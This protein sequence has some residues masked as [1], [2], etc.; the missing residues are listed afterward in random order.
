MHRSHNLIIKV[1]VIILMLPFGVSYAAEVTVNDGFQAARKIESRY[2]NI[3]IESG[4]D[5]QTLVMRL[6]VPESIKSI[7][8]GSVPFSN[9]YTLGDQLDTLFLAVSEV[10]DMN[11]KRFKCNLKICRNRSGLSDIAGRLFGKNIQPGGFYVVAIDTLYIDAE[12]VTVNILG[13]ELS[14]AIQT[15]YFVVPPPA[16]IQEILAGYVEFQLRKYTNTLPR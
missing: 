5:I 9:S 7:I 12:N 6:S 13:H 2:F 14:H 16:K 10:M 11:V 3:Y 8:R 1:L 15:H 4:V